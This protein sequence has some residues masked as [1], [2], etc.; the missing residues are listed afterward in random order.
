[1]VGHRL[2]VLSVVLFTIDRILVHV[3]VRNIHLNATVVFLSPDSFALE[4]LDVYDENCR[5]FVDLHGFVGLHVFLA[6]AA[7]PHVGRV[8]LL[9][10]GEGFDAVPH[11]H[12]VHVFDFLLLKLFERHVVEAV[13]H[14]VDPLGGFRR[15]LEADLEHHVWRLVVLLQK[16]LEV[17]HRFVFDTRKLGYHV[18]LPLQREHGFGLFGCLLDEFVGLGVGGLHFI[19]SGSTAG[20]F[21]QILLEVCQC[22]VFHEIRQLHLVLLVNHLVHLFL[23][24][25]FV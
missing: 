11:R 3:D 4:P 23:R 12:V 17:F 13:R 19:E 22:L 15:L 21:G 6:L 9:S 10:L 18:A 24:V 16:V 1:M 14:A 25:G 7:V 20:I 2:Q 8:Q 5:Y